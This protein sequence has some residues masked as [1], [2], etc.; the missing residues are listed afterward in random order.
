MVIA[1]APIAMAKITPSLLSATAKAV[2]CATLFTPVA[3]IAQS[4]APRLAIANVLTVG[5]EGVQSDAPQD[6]GS[7]IGA[8]SIRGNEAI[9]DDQYQ[10]VVEGFFGEPLTEQVLERLTDE[11]AQLARDEG[12][13]YTRAV[14]DEDAAARGIVAIAIDEG[15]IDDVLIEGVPNAQARSMLARLIGRP[16]KQQELESVLLLV[17][18]IP[19][20]QLRKAKLRRDDGTAILVVTLD[21]KS[22]VGRISADNYGTETFGPV[23]LRG[24]TQFTGVLTASDE[25]R[26]SV[27]INPIEPEELLFASASYQT[28]ITD[29]GITARISGS[30]GRTAPG[31]ELEGSD[32]AGDTLRANA[33]ITVPVKRSKKAS[34]WVD[35]NAAYISIEQDE[36]GALLRDD[37]LVTAA[38]GLRTRFALAGKGF[39]R[40][41]VTVERGLGL[42]GATRLGDPGA[43]RF[44][45]DGV[46]TKYNFNADARIPIAGRFDAYFAVAGQLADR[47]LLGSEEIALG[48][49]YRVRGY[50]F[51][52]V[53]G[54]EGVYGLAE[55]RYRV[56]TDGLPLDF[57]QLYAFADG[58]YVS[59]I[60]QTGGEGSLYSAGPG[61]RGRLGQLDWEVESAFPLGGSGERS[62][63]DGPQ[64]N[65]RT[66]VRF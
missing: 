52:E 17:S 8:V 57:L 43:S 32:I 29:S 11:L 35:A 48:G 19:G 21:R 7:Q 38:L 40:A 25:I 66:G 55:L 6:G 3:G 28:Q 31:G 58:G 24:S 41:G 56:N 26:T 45:G 34:V 14:I 5:T 49:A 65:V 9:R 1:N 63:P 46:Y 53:L 42:L 51:A 36:L 33:Q 10:A 39:V 20:V 15:R 18:D 22:A 30:L 62:D 44:D 23:R 64:I 47:P 59:D 61:L 4:S 27:R 2:L 13:R 16:L 50:N 54:D 60:E 12:Y 37:T